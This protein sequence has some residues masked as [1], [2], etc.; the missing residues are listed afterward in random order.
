MIVRENFGDA[1]MLHRLHRNAVGQAVLFVGAG[2]VKRQTREEGVAGL[3][4][5]CDGRLLVKAT[6]ESGGTLPEQRPGLAEGRQDFGQDFIG[7]N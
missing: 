3:R 4:M 1:F 5:D 7:R 6:Y 2:F